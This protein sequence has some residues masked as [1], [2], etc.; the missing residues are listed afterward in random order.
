MINTIVEDRVSGSIKDRAGLT[1]LKHLTK[2]DCD[3][4]IIS[5]T[6]RLS[7]EDRL[8][9]LINNIQILLDEKIDVYFLHND[10]HLKGGRELSIEEC[11]ILL[12]EAKANADERLKIIEMYPPH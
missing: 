4:V 8:T 5:E 11:I 1:L 3:I 2:N 12:V 9:S 7:R 10:K 6:S